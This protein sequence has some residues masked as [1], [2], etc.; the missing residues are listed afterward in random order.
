MAI[1]NPCMHKLRGDLASPR[2]S[3][4]LELELELGHAVLLPSPHALDLSLE[5]NV[6]SRHRLEHSIVHALK[7][8]F[9]FVPAGSAK[10]RDLGRRSRQ[11]PERTPHRDARPRTRRSVS[12]SPEHRSCDP[13]R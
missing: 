10:L 2:R 9:V 5:H 11:V 6:A 8:S 12:L 7:S 13:S 1:V 3:S 4:E